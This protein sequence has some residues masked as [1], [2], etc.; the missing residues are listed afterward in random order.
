MELVDKDYY[1]P[2]T[3]ALNSYSWVPTDFK[4]V[5][6]GI[7]EMYPNSGPIY[8]GTD[9]TILGKGFNEEFQET[10]YCRFGVGTSQVIV[11]ADILDYD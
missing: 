6:Y 7:T 8:G 11:A 10:A 2:A 4:Y 9:V 3:V 1:L 5:P